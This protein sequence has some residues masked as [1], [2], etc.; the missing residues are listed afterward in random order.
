MTTSAPRASAVVVSEI[1]RR[2]VSGELSEGEA[3]PSEARLMERYRVSKPT[4]REAWRV[5]ESEGL[6][7]VRRGAL[8]G[9]MVRTPSPTSV[10]RQAGIFCN[11]GEPPF[12]TC[13]TPA[14]SLR[15][16]R[17]GAS[18]YRERGRPP[19]S[20]QTRRGGCVG[21]QRPLGVYRR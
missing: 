10:A 9:A 19:E 18:P 21:R 2:I 7:I 5:L 1:R 3:L 8:G 15:A 6:I 20:P 13:I 11:G 14:T 12:Q 4:I 17:R 16:R